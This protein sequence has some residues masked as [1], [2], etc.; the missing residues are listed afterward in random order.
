MADRPSR[1]LVVDD[2]GATRLAMRARIEAMGH[3]VTLASSGEEAFLICMEQPFDLMVSDV[4]M[5][6]VSGVHL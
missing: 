1:V 3:Q 5:G 4:T 2:S 6:A